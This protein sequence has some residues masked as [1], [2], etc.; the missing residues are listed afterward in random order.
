MQNNGNFNR[1]EVLIASDS[2]IVVQMI[3][4]AIFHCYHVTAFRASQTMSN[5]DIRI[6][7]ALA[8]TN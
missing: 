8:H 1:S 4:Q 3:D 5:P 2:Q 6:C 7:K